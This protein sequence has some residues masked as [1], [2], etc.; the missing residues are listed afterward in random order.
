ML[1]TALVYSAIVGGPFVPQ[2][3]LPIYKF[4]WR[5]A[6]RSMPKAPDVI[7][8]VL[9]NLDGTVIVVGSTSNPKGT[10]YTQ[11]ILVRKHAED[12][13]L[14]WEKMIDSLGK[15]GQDTAQSAVLDG[16]GNIYISVSVPVGNFDGFTLMKMS[17]DGSI[18]WTK[19]ADT[20]N[21]RATAFGMSIDKQGFP[22]QVGGFGSN[23]RAEVFAVKWS[24]DGKPVWR[25]RWKS[26]DG[27]VN[28]G[29]DVA[30]GS[31]GDAYLAGFSETAAGG[32]DAVALRLD[33]QNGQV[34]WAKHIRGTGLA[35][36][37]AQAIAVDGAGDAYVT[38]SIYMQGSANSVFAARLDG[39]N[40]SVKWQTPLIEPRNA[41]GEGIGIH[42]DPTGV[43]IGASMYLVTANGVDLTV[44]RFSLD[45]KETWRAS[46]NSGEGLG[47]EA[48][49]FTVDRYGNS[50][51]A[52][53]SSKRNGM[54]NAFV[55]R[56]NPDGKVF[57]QHLDSPENQAQYRPG[58]VAIDNESG[59]VYVGGG[60]IPSTDTDWSLV[61]IEQSPVAVNF[62]A[63]VL[64]GK[65]FQFQPNPE[66]VPAFVRQSIFS[67]GV[68]F[69]AEVPKRGKFIFGPNA[70]E[71]P[72][73]TPGLVEMG[74]ELV[75]KGLRPSRALI[76]MNVVKP[77]P[78][79]VN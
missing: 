74:F 14:I 42:V 53:G 48:S 55:V 26:P 25:T 23:A 47:D 20:G 38:G 61:A 51:I 69:S 7:S 58:S 40:G 54:P 31:N 63:Q 75:R 52:G 37:I 64:L 76:R 71:A 73:D 9:V 12:G 22:I 35:R 16:G 15:G 11:D 32:E 45:G 18:A 3:D 46:A 62:S 43:T 4:A 27:K 33:G 30:I 24:P 67:R 19:T 1:T 60:S 70:F 57:W 41:G 77:P 72:G 65:T 66:T 50:Y 68:S 6:G 56:V 8:K 39:S 21:D 78:N 2:A 36:D 13:K 28:Q 79:S 34:K 44:S 17:P 5:D 29:R 59:T 10:S 49:A